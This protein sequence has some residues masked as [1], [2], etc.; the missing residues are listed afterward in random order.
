MTTTDEIQ[1][2][3]KEGEIIN[4]TIRQ[5]TGHGVYVTLD[6]YSKMTSFLY[7]SKIASGW[8]RNIVRYVRSKKKAVLKVIRA[9]KGRGDV[10]T[11]LRQVSGEECKS[12]LTE[13]KRSD[14]AA[15]F[16]D[17][18]KSKPKQTYQEVLEIE[19]K[20]LEKYDY[21][22]NSLDAVSRKGVDTIQSIDLSQEIKGVIEEP[23]KRIP[24][25]LVEISGVM[26]IKSKKADGIEIIQ[27][28]LA[29]AEAN[30]GGASSI[31]TYMG[32]PSYRIVVKAENFK[33]AEK[34]LYKTV[35]RT[36]T[37][38]EKQHG[39]FNFV[40]LDSKKSQTPQQA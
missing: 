31:L 4:A 38:I 34:A 13:V 18:I 24:V 32:D 3:P 1:G 33:I 40:R 23:S 10:D 9:N 17:L 39:T 19:G 7:I 25:C 26:E 16:L 20:L 28:T 37:N 35:E 29:N 21:L 8:I 22:N 11:A 2:L 5:M 30:K 36:R 14:R 15:T 27:N 6:E 12:K